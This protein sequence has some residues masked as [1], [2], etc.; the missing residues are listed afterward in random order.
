M[1]ENEY[2]S[3][4]LY[5]SRVRKLLGCDIFEESFMQPVR[6]MLKARTWPTGFAFVYTHTHTHKR[7]IYSE[8]VS[9]RN[10]RTALAKRLRVLT[11]IHTRWTISCSFSDGT[12]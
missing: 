6:L 3:A 12:F 8:N 1:R 9:V 5:L 11:F 7:F 4:I 10:M 2:R